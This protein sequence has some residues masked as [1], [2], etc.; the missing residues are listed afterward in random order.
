MT[1]AIVTG[2]SRSIREV[3]EASDRDLARFN[4]VL[5][6]GDR[7]ALPSPLNW[8]LERIG[9]LLAQPTPADWL[10]RGILEGSTLACIFGASGAGKSFVAV[11]LAACVATGRPWHAHATRQGAVVYLAGEG[12]HGLRK[13]FLA[14]SI[15]HNADLRDAPLV[16]SSAAIDLGGERNAIAEAIRAACSDAPVLVIVDTL[17]R[18]L[19][20]GANENSGE[21]LG[22]FVAAADEIKGAFGCAVVLVHHTGHAAGERERGWSGLRGALDWSYSI[23]K[24]DGGPVILTCR[25]AKDHEPPEPMQFALHSVEL[26]WLDDEGCPEKSAA[27][28]VTGRTEAGMGGNQLV[29]MAALRKLVHADKGEPIPVAVWRKSSGLDRWRWRETLTALGERGSIIVEGDHVRPL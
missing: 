11:D 20:S 1:P 21:D 22:P 2:L 14:W 17:H 29:A 18:H 27:L 6:R 3:D 9:D 10:V 24:G 7:E 28:R 25:K 8:R 12:H 15:E 19:A 5:A 23:Q 13:R 26:P 16:L 4:R